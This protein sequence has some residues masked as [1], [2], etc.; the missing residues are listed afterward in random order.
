MN[1]VV[2][3]GVSTGIGHGTTRVLVDECCHVFGSVRKQ[4]GARAG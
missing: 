4:A 3:T 1:A 2:I